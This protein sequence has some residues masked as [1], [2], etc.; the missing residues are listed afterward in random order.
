[1]RKN[2]EHEVPSPPAE[3]TV[4]PLGD[5]S[6]SHGTWPVRQKQENLDFLL[7]ELIGRRAKVVHSSC[8][9]LQ[10]IEGTIADEGKN[11]FL[12]ET[13]KGFRRISKTGTV[14]QFPELS[15]S[16][17]PGRLLQCRPED[18]TKKLASLVSKG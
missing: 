14:F 15:A 18:R 12:F 13:P 4:K 3:Q 16:E 8:R 17:V 11:S 7:G 2:R 6:K 10:G 5:A 1:V 9:D